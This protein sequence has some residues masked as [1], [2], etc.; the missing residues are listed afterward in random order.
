MKDEV[1]VDQ[2]SETPHLALLVNEI[3]EVDSSLRVVWA[4]VVTVVARIYLENCLYVMVVV[5]F[6]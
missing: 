3:D 6:G 2:H 1:G 5:A 4:A